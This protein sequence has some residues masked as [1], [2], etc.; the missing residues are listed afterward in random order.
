[1]STY[2]VNGAG[3]FIG[4]YIANYLLKNGNKVIC[5]DIKP[6]EFWFVISKK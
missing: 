3:G 6:F 5:A 4:G 2:F 1:M